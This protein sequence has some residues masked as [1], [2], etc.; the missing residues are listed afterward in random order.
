MGNMP[1]CGYLMQD[2][3]MNLISLMNHLQTKK[4][5]KH[6]YAKQERETKCFK[7][8]SYKRIHSNDY[9]S[10]NLQKPVQVKTVK[11]NV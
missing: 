10:T 9:T 11:D 4:S 3:R 7:S 6:Q 1:H 8:I 5:I 2:K